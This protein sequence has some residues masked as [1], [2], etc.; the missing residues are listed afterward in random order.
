MYKECP[1]DSA[2]VANKIGIAYHQMMQ[3]DLA[4]RQY[5]RAIKLNK[6]Y[7]EAIN[8]L[9]TVYYAKRNY[10]KAVGLYKKALKQSPE[11]ASIFSNLGTAYFARKKYKDAIKAYTQALALDQLQPSLSWRCSVAFANC[12][13]SNT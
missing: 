3:L 9:G 2:V 4:R 10:R 1:K 5:E 7:S 12:L 6:K 13:E 8:N 11:S